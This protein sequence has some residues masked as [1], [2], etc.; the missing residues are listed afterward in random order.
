MSES[1]SQ[2]ST[3]TPFK[4][5]SFWQQ[6]LYSQTPGYMRCLINACS[7]G[8]SQS[9]EA[10]YS[11]DIYLVSCSEEEKRESSDTSGKPESLPMPHAQPSPIFR[12]PLACYQKHL[13]LSKCFNRPHWEP[14]F[15][16]GNHRSRSDMT[17]VLR[18]GHNH[19]LHGPGRPEG[20]MPEVLRKTA[21][22]RHQCLRA[23]QMRKMLLHV[24][25]HT[26][27]HA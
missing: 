1:Y 22:P 5:K 9:Q 11:N 15:L 8:W 17:A 16:Q 20:L 27:A 6:S 21:Q 13:K 18:E 24:Q 26:H 4:P 10:T 14:G 23:K 7:V 3:E 25:A 19:V 2:L 12:A